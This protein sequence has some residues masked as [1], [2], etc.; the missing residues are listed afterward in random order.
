[1]RKGKLAT[2]AIT[3]ALVVTV[4]PAAMAAAP[5]GTAQQEWWAPYPPPPAAPP[6]NW[7]QAGPYAP[8]A[9]VLRAPMPMAAMDQAVAW[10]VNDGGLWVVSGLFNQGA[11]QRYDPPTDTWWLGAA[12]PFP[13]IQE[14]MDGCYGLDMQGHEVIV[15]FPDTTG[16][17]ALILQ[18]Y[19]ITANSWLQW[20]MPPMFPPMGQWAH[21]I[22]SMYNIT[23]QNVCYISGGATVGNPG[24]GNLSTLWK[25]SPATN[26]MVNLG[27]YNHI[28]GGFNHHASWYVPWV[29]QQGAICVGGGVD[30]N[31]VLWPSTQCYDRA[32]KVFLPP[33]VP[34]GPL[35]IPLGGMADGW[36]VDQGQYQIWI[37]NGLDPALNFIGQSFFQDVTTGVW[38][39][40]PPM[41]SATYRTEGDDWN[42]HLYAE[43]GSFGL[44]AP[45][46]HNQFLVQEEI[47][48][49]AHVF[50][51]KMTWKYAAAPGKYKVMTPVSVHDQAHVLLPGATVFGDYTLPNGTIVSMNKVTAANG[52]AKF[53][54]NTAQVGL[55]QFCV[56]NITKAGYVYD[57][58]SNHLNPPCKSLQVGP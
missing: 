43:G 49:K 3:L 18:V 26:Q 47:V 41:A 54:L 19:D 9:W 31:L 33:N 56:T 6:G 23:G 39:F 35:P 15:L 53:P 34:L 51:I 24:G 46:P 58:A 16:V 42:G 11:A 25:Y 40:G 37:A 30:L 12:A 20:P 36:K 21:D 28:P 50:R 52:V 32:A 13:V 48:L 7:V 55:H 4:L 8:V 1:M 27:N 44:F 38:L 45:T 14:P 57:P 29:G 10:A 22:V 5:E 17:S 2:L